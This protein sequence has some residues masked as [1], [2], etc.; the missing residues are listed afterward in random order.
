[1]QLQNG[2]EKSVI[3]V[4]HI[5]LDQATRWGIMEF[6]LYAFVYW[7][8]QLSPYLLGKLYTVRTD[9]KNLVSVQFIDS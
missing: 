5:L 1:M 7:A 4:S 2:I 9:H 6:E 8:K 3:F